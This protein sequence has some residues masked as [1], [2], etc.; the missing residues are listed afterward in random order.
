[1]ADLAG[2][3][4]LST[5]V[6]SLQNGVG[7]EEILTEILP[8]QSI[9][10]G[11]ITLPVTVPQVG[12]IAVSKDKGGITLAPVSPGAELADV[13]KALRQ[14]GFTVATHADY[15]S[16][17]W[18][19]LLMNIICNAT[20]AIL[21]MPPAKALSY[22][23]IFDLELGALRETLAVM[24]AKG[25]RVIGLPAYPVPILAIVIRWLP[26][27]ILQKILKPMIVG[28]RG[29]KLPSLL[30]DMQQGRNQSE[31]NV[32]NK[33]IA[34]T[35]IQLGIPTPINTSLSQLLNEII[36]GEEHW[37]DYQDNPEALCS[38]IQKHKL[39]LEEV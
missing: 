10:A 2:R 25:I 11:S 5:R 32:L 38:Y 16:L 29:D 13:A 22:P 8:Q 34:V 27:P 30:I 1:V 39:Q 7:N 35:G 9:L 6:L 23:E 36:K 31:I 3:L 19:K 26:Y 14:A 24:Q 33:V 18:S 17:K 37:S 15:Q 12:T 28:G 20:P 4:A 21:G